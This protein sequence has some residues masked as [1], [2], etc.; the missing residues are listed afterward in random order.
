MIH[1]AC[2]GCH[3]FDIVGPGHPATVYVPHPDAPDDPARGQ[4][5][6][7]DRT[8]LKHSHADGCMPGDDGNYPLHF[9]FMPGMAPVDMTGA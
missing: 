7:T 4:H 3:A 2:Q 5:V 6:L 8:K 1:I 9:T